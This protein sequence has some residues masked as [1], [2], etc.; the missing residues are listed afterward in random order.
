MIPPTN[1]YYLCAPSKYSSSAHPPTTQ[2]PHQSSH[3]LHWRCR[4]DT[5]T[6][7]LTRWGEG[8]EQICQRCHGTEEGQPARGDARVGQG[9]FEWQ[10]GEE[11]EADAELEAGEPGLVRLVVGQPRPAREEALNGL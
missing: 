6:A 5:T 8:R 1:D 2:T 4:R 3:G 11:E 7:L 9:D 10:G